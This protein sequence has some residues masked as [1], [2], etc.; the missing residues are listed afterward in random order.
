MMAPTSNFY[1][2]PS[3]TWELLMGALLAHATPPQ[4]VDHRQH[5][6]VTVGLGSVFRSCPWRWWR[7]VAK[8]QHGQWVLAQLC[9]LARLDAKHRLPN[10]VTSTI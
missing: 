10:E 9:E 5:R 2:L 7:V 6:S 8:A 4:L 3:R 1:M